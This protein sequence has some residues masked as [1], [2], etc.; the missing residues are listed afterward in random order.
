M[1]GLERCRGKCGTGAPEQVGGSAHRVWQPE[2]Q[3]LHCSVTALGNLRLSGRQI[4]SL[5]P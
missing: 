2:L 5:G 3:G 4:G 1:A